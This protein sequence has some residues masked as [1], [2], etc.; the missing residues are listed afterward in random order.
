MPVAVRVIPIFVH[1]FSNLC[2]YNVCV[3]VKS[4]SVG[5]FSH[6]VWGAVEIGAI[7]TAEEGNVV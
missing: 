5:N 2:V 7:G 1:I 4:V 6:C 3:L